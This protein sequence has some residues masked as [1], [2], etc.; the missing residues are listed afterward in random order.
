M[1]LGNADKLRAYR[2]LQVSAMSDAPVKSSTNHTDLHALRPLSRTRIGC[3]I[4]QNTVSPD[5]APG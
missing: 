1:G 4:L 3:N 2:P 5:H